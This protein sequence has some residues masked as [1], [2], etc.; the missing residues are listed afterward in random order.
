MSRDVLTIGSTMRIPLF[1]RGEYSQWSERFTNYLEEQTDEEVM[2]NPIKNGDQLL[3][4]VTQ[5]SIA[6]ATSSEQ[7]PLKDKSMWSDKEKMIR[8]IDRLARSFLIQGLPNDIFSLIDSNKSAKDLWDALARQMLGSEYGEQDTK[9]AVLY[10]YETFKA[11]EG[12]LLLDTYICY[13]QVINDLKKCGYSKDNCELNF[14]FLNNLQ[15]EWKQYATMM[16]QNKNLMDIN[17]DTLYNI[18]KQNQGNVND[19]MGLKKKTV[20]VTSD[21]LAL[22]AEKKNKDEQVLLAEDH[23]WMESVVIR[24][25]R[26]MLICSSRHRWKRFCQIKRKAHHPKKKPLLRKQIADQEILF[27]MRRQLVELDENVVAA[28]KLPILNLYEFDLWKMRIE[29]VVDGVVQPIAPTTAE[30][31]LDKKNELKARGTLLMALPDKHR[32]KF[33]TY[34]D[35]KSLME[36]IE[37]R[38]GGNKETKKVQKTLLKQQ[39]EN[40]SGSSSKSLDQFHDRLQKLIIQLEILGESLSQKDINL[41]FLRSL[42]SEWRTHTLI[43]RNKADLEDQSLDDLFNNLKIY[44]AEVKSSSSTSHT[45][46]NIAFVSSENTDITNESV[47]AVSSV[48]VASTKLPV[49][50]LPNVDNLS[51]AEMDLKWQMAML[52]MRAR[53]FLQGTGRN[54]GA[55][56]TTSI[57]FDMSKVKCYNGHRRGHFAREYSVT[58]LVAMIGAFR[59]MK[60]QQIMPSWHSP[61]QVQQVLQVLIVRDNALVELREKFKA[62]EKERDELKH[63]LEKF[64]T[65]SKNLSKLLESQITNKTGLGYDNQVFHSQVFASDELNIFESDDSVPTSPVHDSE[66]VPTVFNIESSTTNPTK[67]IFQSNR[68]FAPIIED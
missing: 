15:L 46:H 12:E 9:V 8:K 14:K 6:G 64:Q 7:P 29:Q 50:A 68:P 54:L 26:L 57:G 61:P 42:L 4:T 30:Q 37:K 47:S 18:L 35:A 27:K 39:Y 24:I 21:P 62:T 63:T 51:D 58:V 28:A 31:R 55:N 20:V 10:E 67:D 32:L 19:A 56:E 53:R 52:T 17:I 1:F 25:K 33:N 34:K 43:W 48:T 41:K 23:A 45:T 59:Q 13:L 11:T 38:F 22:I 40:F 44:E 16:R 3:P 65:S 60:N 49:S 5:V 66:I 36:A 2:I